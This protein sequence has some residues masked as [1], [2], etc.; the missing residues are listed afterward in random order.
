MLARWLF[1]LALP[2]FAQ[3]AKTV[4]AKTVINDEAGKKLLLGEHKLS[5]QWLDKAPGKVM[6]TDR[7][8]TLMIT[9]E[10]KEQNGV[11]YVRIDG[12][13]TEVAAKTFKFRGRIRTLVSHI[14]DGKVC[15]RNGEYTFLIKGPRAFWRMQAMDNP[16][17]QAADYVDIYWK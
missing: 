7:N 1:L 4:I 10:A 13:I 11:G 15:D 8:G 14:A 9:G 2:A 17:D 6:V 16:C 5:L 3:D 12:V